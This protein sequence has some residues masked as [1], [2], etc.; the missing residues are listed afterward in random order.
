MQLA[1]DLC[2]PLYQ[3]YLDLMKAYNTLD[4]DRTFGIPFPAWHGVHQGDN[5]S[6]I[7][8]NIVVDAV[9]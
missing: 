6:P 7:V 2:Q 8:F 5:I 9:V 4:R 3:V 1:S